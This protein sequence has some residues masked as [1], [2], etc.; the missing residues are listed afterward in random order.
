MTLLVWGCER[1]RK[2]GQERGPCTIIHLVSAWSQSKFVSVPVESS[3]SLRGSA[4]RGEVQYPA[5]LGANVNSGHFQDSECRER[6]GRPVLQQLDD[7]PIGVHGE[8][9]AGLA[10]RTRIVECV[11]VCR[12][13]ERHKN[14]GCK[15]VTHLTDPCVWFRS[16]RPSLPQRSSTVRLGYP[17]S[18]FRTRSL[19]LRSLCSHPS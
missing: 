10:A 19:R 17:A 1:G 14:E 9:I 5:I 12:P 3:D 13:G 4:E 11:G 15:G 2:S 18:R 7:A 6:V 16:C 8:R